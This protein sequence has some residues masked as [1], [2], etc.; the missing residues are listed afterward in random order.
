M[1]NKHNK[2]F[3]SYLFSHEKY[4]PKPHQP[5]FARFYCDDQNVRV[6]TEDQSQNTKKSGERSHTKTA[7]IPGIELLLNRL[8]TFSFRLLQ[9]YKCLVVVLNL[10]AFLVAK[11][12]QVILWQGKFL[13][14][15]KS[16]LAQK[17]VPTCLIR[18]GESSLHLH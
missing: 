16:P 14:S 7:I 18:I 1:I 3:T 13:D 17:C 9:Y 4:L 6:R 11:V 15:K 5:T 10:A 8:V 2:E 12:S